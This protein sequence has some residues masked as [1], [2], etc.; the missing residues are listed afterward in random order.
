MSSM[1]EVPI[2]VR[3]RQKSGMSGSKSKGTT[4]MSSPTSAY[5]MPLVGRSCRS[6]VTPASS[7]TSIGMLRPSRS[8]SSMVREGMSASFSGGSSASC[9]S[10]SS[11]VSFTSPSSSST[12][13]LERTA[14]SASFSFFASMSS[15]PVSGR[16]LTVTRWPLEM[17]Y[18]DMRSWKTGSPLSRRLRN[19]ASGFSKRRGS[20]GSRSYSQ[21]EREPSMKDRPRGKPPVLNSRRRNSS[22]FK[23]ASIA[24]A[25]KPSFAILVSVSRMIFSISGI[26]ASSLMPFMPTEYVACCSTVSKPSESTDSPRPLSRSVLYSGATGVPMSR[27]SSTSSASSSCGSRVLSLM[28]QFTV[29]SGLPSAPAG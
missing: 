21:L 9:F 2:S 6:T 5:T 25:S 18:L 14:S 23:D 26:D 27:S 8:R 24:D 10:L 12:E 3:Q 19:S 13:S 16:D 4:R 20:K 28:S 7:P 1:S 11:F 15:N 29:M 22:E 17:R